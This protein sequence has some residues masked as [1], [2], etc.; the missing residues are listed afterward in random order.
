MITF[1]KP[2]MEQY[3]KTFTIANFTVSPDEKQLVFSMNLNGHFNLWA[4]DLPNAFPY[5]LTSINQSCHELIYDKKGQFMIAG[6]DQ[7]GDEN[8]QLYALPPNGG[9]LKEIVHHEN[10][11]NFYPILSKES[12]KLYYSSSKGNPSYLNIYC[13]EL[14]SGKEST[15]IQGTEASTLLMDVSPEGTRYLFYKH[16]SNT[17]TRLYMKDGDNEFCLTP[18]TDRQHT[19]NEALFVTENMVYLLTDYD[20]DYSYLASYDLE[21]HTFTKLKELEKE[22]FTSLRLDKKN[23]KLY[24]STEKGVED[25]LYSY[26]LNNQDWEQIETPFSIIEK[27]VVAESGNLYVLGKTATAPTNIYTFIDQKWAEITHNK[28]PGVNPSDL[29]EPEIVKFSSYDGLEIEALFFKANEDTANGQLIFWPHGGPQ[30]A[31]RKSFRAM[32][33]FFLSHGY[34]IFAPNFRGSTGYGLEFMR[35]VEG[36]WGNGPRLDNIAALDWLIKNG[37]AQKGEIILLGGSFGG[38]MS[39]LLHGRHAE[40]FSMVVDLFGP[41]NLFSFIDSVPEDWKPVMDEWVGHPIRDKEKLTE[42]SPISYI[43]GMTRPM[44]IIQG[45]NDPRVVQKESDQIVRALKEAGREVE[46]M[47]LEDEGHGFSKKENEIAV[48]NRILTFFEK[49]LHTLNRV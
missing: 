20:S 22:S 46:Y 43:G 12:N 33:Q 49:H 42:F 18:Q 26:N 1:P 14:D 36:E 34:S 5:Q 25:Q 17:N 13:L 32:F 3:I 24:I 7:D 48:Y 30:F 38:Y 6:F 27:M 4:M 23:Q 39:L 44:L 47:V 31:E 9:V 40:Y 41:S 16:F 37:H 10:C 45:A 8:T 35:M 2:D 19:A 28:V 15:I 29:V 11:R 21:T